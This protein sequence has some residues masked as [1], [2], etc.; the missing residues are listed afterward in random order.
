MT[1]RLVGLFFCCIVLLLSACKTDVATAGGSVLGDADVIIVKADTFAIS[2]GIT[3]CH[4]IIASPDSFLIGEIETGYGVLKADILTQFACPLGYKF[5]DNATVDSVCL[6]LY[7]RSWVGDESSPLAINVYEIDRKVLEYAPVRPYQTDLDILDYCSLDDSTLLLYNER[8]IVASEKTDSVYSSTEGVYLP[9]VRCKLSSAFAQR[10]FRMRQYDDQNEFNDFFRGLYITSDFGSST[11]LH[12][13]DMCLGV[14]YH[15]DYRKSGSDK[16][17][18]IYDMKGF[19]AN[20][21]VRQ[22]N[23]FEYLDKQ[24]LIQRLEKDSSTL[25]YIVAPAGIYTRMSLPMKQMQEVIKSQLIYRDTVKRAYINQ[26]ELR[27]DVLN[28][29]DGSQTDIQPNDW[30]QPAQYMLLIKEGSEERFFTKKE[31][32]ADTVAILSSLV[33]GVD[34]EGNAIYYYTYDLSTLLTNQLRMSNAQDTL[35]MLLVPVSVETSSATSSNT[36]A[37]VSVKQSQTISATKIRSAK[38]IENPMT[39]KVV[40]SG[41]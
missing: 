13:A 22:L 24:E 10:F 34:S 7:Y 33:S 27:V 23:R 30:L 29:Y 18:T 25:N 39:L 6:F 14:Y 8:L 40:Y 21:E 3:E 5:P 41:F 26:A 38:N 9:M 16:D 35:N 4:H 1:R 32:P 31:L 12:I 36:S 37:L 15:F 11:I 17:T 19:Y 28:I 20:S 2:S